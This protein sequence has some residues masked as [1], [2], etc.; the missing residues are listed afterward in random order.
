MAQ[1]Y[2]S[3]GADLCSRIQPVAGEMIYFV[4]P[5]GEVRNF[6]EDYPEKIVVGPVI[7]LIDD[8]PIFSLM[9]TLE[10]IQSYRKS[11]QRIYQQRQIT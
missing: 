7:S 11:P 10:E 5:S 8:R 6:I 9:M 1:R 2:D 4:T 3:F